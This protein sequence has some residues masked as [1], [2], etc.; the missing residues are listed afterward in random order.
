M[1]SNS[2]SD[3]L[4]VVEWVGG[5]LVVAHEILMIWGLDIGLGQ[6][7]CLGL[8]N[9][10]RWNLSFKVLVVVVGLCKVNHR[11]LDILFP[12]RSKHILLSGSCC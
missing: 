2:D 11:R 3:P 10:K 9:L 4:K 5:V 7:L 8:A 12:A 6:G 1:Y